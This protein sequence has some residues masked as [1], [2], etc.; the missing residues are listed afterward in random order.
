MEGYI[1]GVG[2]G[3]TRDSQVGTKAMNQF[4]VE[5]VA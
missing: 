4:R 3:G 5:Q 1:A 2:E